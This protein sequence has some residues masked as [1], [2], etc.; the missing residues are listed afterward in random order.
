MGIASGGFSALKTSTSARTSRF[1]LLKEAEIIKTRSVQKQLV[2]VL[3][4][5]LL[6]F[7]T[8]FEV[9]KLAKPR[10]A[11]RGPEVTWVRHHALEPTRGSP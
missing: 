1:R 9:W 4:R 2:L 10:L 5:L 7:F 3:M 6:G 11:D 8:G